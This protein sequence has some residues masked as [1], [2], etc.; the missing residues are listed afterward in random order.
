MAMRLLVDL[1]NCWSIQILL[2]FSLSLHVLLLPL[3][4]IRRCKAS[5]L[6]RVPLWLAYHMTDM[7][8]IYAFGL[9]SLSG[10][11]PLQTSP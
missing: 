11:R 7:I 6:L 4:G 10:L 9:L 2:L 8:G 3:A 5:V 1:W